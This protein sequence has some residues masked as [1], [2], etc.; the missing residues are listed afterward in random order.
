MPLKR[1]QMLSPK[2]SFDATGGSTG[3]VP[4]LPTPGTIPLM[5][6]GVAGIGYRQRRQA[7]A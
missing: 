4:A 1:S 7:N 2:V 3:T 6:M 5:S